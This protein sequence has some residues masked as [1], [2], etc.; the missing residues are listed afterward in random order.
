MDNRGARVR[1]GV[2]PFQRPYYC[3]P[4]CIHETII[5]CACRLYTWLTMDSGS[6]WKKKDFQ[7]ASRLQK[8]LREYGK[9]FWDPRCDLRGNSSCSCISDCTVS[10]IL[11]ED[12]KFH[13]NKLAMAQKINLANF[14]SLKIECDAFIENLPHDA[15]LFFSDSTNISAPCA[16]F[17]VAIPWI[18]GVYQFFKDPGEAEE[19]YSGCYCQHRHSHA[20][21]SVPSLPIST[22][23]PERRQPSR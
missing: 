17:V 1:S 11:I 20:R 15:A 13:T 22:P 7:K 23:R 6:V 16:Y 12:R 19:Q 2:L 10:R 8:T 18:L 4:T 3:N 5:N 21:Q 14:V 9:R